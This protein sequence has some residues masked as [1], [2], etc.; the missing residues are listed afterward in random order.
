[1]GA[2]LVATGVSRPRGWADAFHDKARLKVDNC[3]VGT[4]KIDIIT[5]NI[6]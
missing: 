3:P 2:F 5:L 4:V 6:S 1:M